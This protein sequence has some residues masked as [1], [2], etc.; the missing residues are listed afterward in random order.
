MI[1]AIE[2]PMGLCSVRWVGRIGLKVAVISYCNV[3]SDAGAGVVQVPD[4]VFVEGKR[5]ARMSDGQSLLACE[6]C[7]RSM[8]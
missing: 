7:K 8:R 1:A 3:R 5:W 4:S 2:R 6:V